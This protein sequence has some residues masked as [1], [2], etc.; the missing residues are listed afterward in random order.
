MEPP[1]FDNISM[2]YVIL[3]L[4]MAGLTAYYAHFK[5]RNPLAWFAL[6]LLFGFFAPLILLFIPR[7][8]PDGA[9]LKQDNEPMMNVSNPDPSLANQ[10]PPPSPLLTRSKDEDKLWYYLDQDHQQIGPVSVVALRELWNTGRLELSSYVWSE[11]ML[12][13]KK[14]DELPDLKDVLNKPYVM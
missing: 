11:G 1:S 3:F 6:T 2:F 14:V 13:W 4:A 12:D 8:G 7:L 10:I 5:G 9:P